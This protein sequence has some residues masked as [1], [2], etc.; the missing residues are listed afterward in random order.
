MPYR[1]ISI[2]VCKLW[3]KFD[4]TTTWSYSD[5]SIM[6]VINTKADIAWCALIIVCN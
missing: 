5:V 4:V 1:L 3:L 2:I 6:S